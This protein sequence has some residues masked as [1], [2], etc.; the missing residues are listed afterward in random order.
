MLLHR[1]TLVIAPVIASPLVLV[2][3]AQLCTG[4]NNIASHPNDASGYNNFCALRLQVSRIVVLRQERM[5]LQKLW[6]GMPD[7]SSTATSGA[8][9]GPTTTASR[10][11]GPGPTTTASRHRQYHVALPLRLQCWVQRMA[12]AMGQGLD[13]S[14]KTLLLQDCQKGV[15]Y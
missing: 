14:K 8:S 11:P 3:T 10:G 4:H 7:H 5:V 6:R 12:I 13:R 1:A 2:A 15:R 9:S